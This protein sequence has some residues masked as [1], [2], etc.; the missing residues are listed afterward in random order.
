MAQATWDWSQTGVK[1]HPFMHGFTGCLVKQNP[2][3][4]LATEGCET[5]R[6]KIQS[7]HRP[8]G[9]SRCYQPVLV[10][11]YFPHQNF[12]TIPVDLQEWNW[13]SWGCG[14]WGRMGTE[15]LTLWRLWL[16]MG[17]KGRLVFVQQFVVFWIHP[18]RAWDVLV[19]T[20]KSQLNRQGNLIP[21]QPKCMDLKKLDF[22]EQQIGLQYIAEIKRRKLRI[23]P[24]TTRE[25]TVLGSCSRITLKAT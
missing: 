5:L 15:S 22:E 14:G 21:F 23:S 16:E 24:K 2:M 4:S 7:C 9:Y 1:T 13:G 17:Y 11:K 8:W 25:E 6:S 10:F 20:C 3:V 12:P 19:S 18:A